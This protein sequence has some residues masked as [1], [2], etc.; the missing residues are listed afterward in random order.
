MSVKITI[1][2]LGL[3]AMAAEIFGGWLVV[4]KRKWFQISNE[5]FLALGSGF[6]IA[7]VII[8]LIPLSFNEISF[9]N[10]SLW[11]LFGFSAMHFFEHTVVGHLHFGEET[12]HDKINVNKFVGFSTS[13]GLFIH[14]FF[15]GFMIS[16]ALQFN[17]AVGI[18]VFIG[19]ILHKFPEGLTVATIMSKAT[20][21][22][23]VIMRTIIFVS[24]GTLLGIITVFFISSFNT[25]YLGYIFAFSAGNAL[26]IGGSDLIPEVNRSEN[27]ITPIIVFVGMLLF[28]ISKELIEFGLKN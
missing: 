16:S 20:E 10:A 15:D 8:E 26:Y 13:T 7:L 9:A 22:V 5:Y 4:K 27:R 6:L 2:L 11:I 1:I 18:A 28:Y 3:L 23:S 19:I 12:H 24:S 21:S 25:T 14:A 17:F